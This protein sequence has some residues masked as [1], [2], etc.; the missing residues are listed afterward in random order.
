MAETIAA[1]CNQKGVKKLAKAEKKHRQSNEKKWQKKTQKNDKN[2]TKKHKKNDEKGITNTLKKHIKMSRKLR[3][4][5]GSKIGVSLG[6]FAGQPPGARTNGTKRAK[7]APQK[8]AKQHQKV[9]TK[10]SKKYRKTAQMRPTIFTKKYQKSA[11]FRDILLF[12]RLNL[13]AV[14]GAFLACFGRAVR[15]A[16][17]RGP[18]A[19]LRNY[20]KHIK[21]IKNIRLFLHFFVCFWRYFFAHFR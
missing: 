3:A 10:T 16:L 11:L 2:T 8:C 12:F 19:V 13:E 1:K 20:E 7:N 15:C 6:L 17:R 4:Q 9:A 14:F 21:H 18:P 5:A